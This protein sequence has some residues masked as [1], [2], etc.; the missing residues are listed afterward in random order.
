MQL[1]ELVIIF[2]YNINAHVI[3]K[4]NY[5]KNEAKSKQILIATAG[6][7]KLLKMLMEILLLDLC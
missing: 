5:M 2:T 7:E 3:F 1:A 4:S 6:C